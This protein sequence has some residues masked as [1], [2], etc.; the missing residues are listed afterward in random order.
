MALR[1]DQN[2][3]LALFELYSQKGLLVTEEH[4]ECE[5]CEN[6]MPTLA[7]QEAANDEL[8]LECT[9]CGSALAEAQERKVLYRIA[10]DKR[11]RMT[12]KPAHARSGESNSDTSASDEPL[13]ER[14]QLVLIAMKQLG[15]IDSDTRRTT[16]VIAA[17]ALGSECDANALKSVMSDL[18]TRQLIETKK[19]RGGG[20]WLSKK[21]RARAEK[22]E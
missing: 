4:I 19:G 10:E 16:D 21:G 22:L 13:A 8:P 20:C 17:R 15:A 5:Q 3:I 11:E 2:Q 12:K 6:M 14:A 9:I 18:N 7:V 1:A